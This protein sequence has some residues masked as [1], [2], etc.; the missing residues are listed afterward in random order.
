MTKPRTSPACSAARLQRAMSRTL[1]AVIA[2]ALLSSC[3]GPSAEKNG[4]QSPQNGR[5]VGQAETSGGKTTASPA[6]SWVLQG[7]GART[8]VFPV[9]PIR[10]APAMAF[11]R[12]FAAGVSSAA[13]AEGRMLFLSDGDGIVSAVDT[14]TGIDRW[15]FDAGATVIG[16]PAL[17]AGNLLFGTVGGS[18]YCLK[19]TDGSVVWQSEGLG[20][21][22]ASPAVGTGRI[23]VGI[24]DGRVASYQIVDGASQWTTNVDS[25]H[26]VRSPAIDEGRIY[27]TTSGGVCVALDAT[28]GHLI[29]SVRPGGG[30]TTAPA[31]SGSMVFVGTRDDGID[32]LAGTDGNV[33]WHAGLSAPI[34]A[35]PAV[36]GDRLFAAGLD[37]YVRAYNARTGSL[38]W[39]YQTGAGLAVPPAVAGDVVTAGSRDG[40]VYGIAADDGTLLWSID[41]GEPVVTPFS[42]VQ[43]RFAVAGGGNT[44]YVV[45]GSTS[46]AEHSRPLIVPG[47]GTWR[48]TV[49]PIPR[50]L[51]VPVDVSGTYTV[52]LTDQSLVPMQVTVRDPDGTDI[53]TNLGTGGSENSLPAEIRVQLNAGRSYGLELVPAGTDQA[54]LLDTF[55]LRIQLLRGS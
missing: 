27:V 44:L 1:F 40:R 36:Q 14:S 30:A 50:R 4:S 13:A 25:G 39:Q 28:D 12:W 5:G 15:T 42:L 38:L 32:A 31:V 55:G 29:W 19:E 53:A 51:A 18:L 37:S 6:G 33:V 48:Y 35:A 46:A 47:T 49:A 7:D 9:E 45:D 54:H 52:T 20:E 26:I 43:H 8:G 10:S 2:A 11:S 34:V 24:G 22:A 16:A 3:G 17:A 21:I 23:Y 41:L